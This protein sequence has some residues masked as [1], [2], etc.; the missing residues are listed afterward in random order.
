MSNSISSWTPG[1]LGDYHFKAPLIG[2]VGMSVIANNGTYFLEGS[3]A[4]NLTATGVLSLF[5]G[6]LDGLVH[7][8]NYYVQNH[9]WNKGYT[10]PGT[11]GYSGICPLVHH[12]SLTLLTMNDNEV[13]VGW[14]SCFNPSSCPFPKGD[15]PAPWF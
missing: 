10:F 2:G 5:V 13:L 12:T 3:S 4:P 6:G 11:N 15:A 7:E 14:T 9:T 1:N 8:Y